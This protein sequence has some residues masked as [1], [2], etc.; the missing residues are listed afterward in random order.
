MISSPHSLPT[1]ST[2]RGD[3]THPGMSRAAAD[4][5]LAESASKKSRPQPRAG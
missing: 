4:G 1:D 3:L 5:R 2:T